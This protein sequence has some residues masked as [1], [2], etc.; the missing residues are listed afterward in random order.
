MKF[1]RGFEMKWPVVLKECLKKLLENIKDVWYWPQR[2]G[3]GGPSS[4]GK[5]E[6]T[7]QVYLDVETMSL[8]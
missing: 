6:W 4:R 1:L 8:M 5:S 2:L 3:G 7:I